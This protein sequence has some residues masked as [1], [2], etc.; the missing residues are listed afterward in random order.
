MEIFHIFHMQ[1]D[2]G[3]Q[4]KETEIYKILEKINL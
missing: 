3:I 2:H 4:E 1:V